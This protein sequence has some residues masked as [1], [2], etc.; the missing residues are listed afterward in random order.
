[1]PWWSRLHHLQQLSIEPYTSETLTSVGRLIDLCDSSFKE[2]DKKM[3]DSNIL[4]VDRE[5]AEKMREGDR[6]Y[7]IR[8][9]F[10]RFPELK[11]FEITRSLKDLNMGENPTVK[12]INKLIVHYIRKLKAGFNKETACDVIFAKIDYSKDLVNAEFPI[13]AT[14]EGKPLFSIL[15]EEKRR[16]ALM[17]TS[18]IVRDTEISEL[19]KSDVLDEFSDYKPSYQLLEP[20]REEKEIAEEDADLFEDTPF[21]SKVQERENQVKKSFIENSKG[22]INRYYDQILTR[23]RLSGISQKSMISQI[24]NT[25]SSMQALFSPLVKLCEKE[26]V[27]LGSNGEIIWPMSEN[28]A[29]KSLKKR[30]PMIRYCLMLRDLNFGFQHKNKLKLKANKLKEQMVALNNETRESIEKEREEQLREKLQGEGLLEEEIDDLINLNYNKSKKMKSKPDEHKK[31]DKNATSK[32]MV[33]SLIEGVSSR[34]DFDFSLR[35]SQE[36]RFLKLE[37]QWLVDRSKSANVSAQEIETLSINLSECVHKLRRLKIKLDKESL[38]NTGRLMWSEHSKVDFDLEDVEIEKLEDFLK[39][40]DEA[41]MRRTEDET[42]RRKARGFLNPVVLRRDLVNPVESHVLPDSYAS[43]SF[44]ENE[45]SKYLQEYFPVEQESGVPVNLRAQSI[46][47]LTPEQR[48]NYKQNNPEADPAKDPVLRYLEQ[49]YGGQQKS[50][51]TKEVKTK[52]SK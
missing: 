36:E 26:R 13:E 41:F 30:E 14:S 39:L 40:P 52:K 44:W 38:R 6:L 1:M 19:L 49:R 35:D 18:R 25:P 32:V 9:L 2:Y 47:R 28:K 43:E 22:L 16:E 27:I 23:D 46:L 31:L 45:R 24:T 3:R 48:Q 10:D 33:K 7:F 17:K 42:E 20:K 21:D 4:P 29:V 34:A 15:T 11:T 5:K 50:K 12:L 37:A 8:R 51:S